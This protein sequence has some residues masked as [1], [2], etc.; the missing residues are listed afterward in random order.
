MG[1]L[2]VLTSEFFLGVI[3]GLILS[4]V[5]AC[6][7]AVFTV[8]QQRR[9][10]KQRIE[11]AALTARQQR[12]EQKQI[13]KNFCA[14]T[15][16]NIRQIV[17]DMSELRTKTKVI[18]GDYLTLMD[19]EIN[20]FGRNRK[21]IILLPEPLRDHVRKFVTDCGLRRAEIGNFVAQFSS[22]SKLADD[23]LGDGRL[24]DERR[25]RDESNALLDSANKALDELL[26]RVRDSSALLDEIR[27]APDDHEP[28]NA[29][30]RSR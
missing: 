20:V 13:I 21:H 11:L 12:K 8:R 15:I 25:T 26:L 22:K 24:P 28:P 16:K 30:L 2:T 10:Q 29:S 19:V 27:D 6:V 18:H 1:V 23:F 5:G 4:V 3:V 9:A 7:L 14:D 17:D